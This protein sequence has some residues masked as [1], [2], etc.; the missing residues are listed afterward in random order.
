MFDFLNI[1]LV[2]LP[3]HR[4]P[5]FDPFIL[6]MISATGFVIIYGVEFLREKLRKKR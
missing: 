5:D 1:L 6:L 4:N 2:K 3:R